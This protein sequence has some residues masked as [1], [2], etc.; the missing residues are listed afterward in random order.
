MPTRAAL[1]KF[2]SIFRIELKDLEEDIKDLLRILEQRKFGHQI[3]NYVY[4]ENKGLLL[5]E[6]SC[7]RDLLDQLSNVDACQYESVEALIAN[8][9]EKL[10]SRI[11]DCSFPDAVH[12][13]VQRKLEKVCTYILS[14]DTAQR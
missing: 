1:D 3:T 7:V 4:M 12:N 13:L 5:H 8:I 14:P 11:S 10:D 9:R 2:I 6:I